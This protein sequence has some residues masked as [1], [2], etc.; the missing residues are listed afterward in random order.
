MEKKSSSYKKEYTNNRFN[1][2]NKFQF[3]IGVFYYSFIRK[4]RT[5][6]FVS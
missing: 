5:C 4:I 1:N 3:K 6:E 2:F